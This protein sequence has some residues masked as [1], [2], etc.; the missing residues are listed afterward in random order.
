[1]QCHFDTSGSTEFDSLHAV[2]DLS[3]VED[4][5]HIVEKE[6]S[7]FRTKYEEVKMVNDAQSQQIKKLKVQN[8]TLL[9]MTASGAAS[10]GTKEQAGRLEEMLQVKL[11]LNFRPVI[12]RCAVSVRT[13]FST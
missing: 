7:S 3:Q 12:E 8:L 1:M 4:R 5:R 13:Q 10:G 6:L 9:N 11:D 2:Y